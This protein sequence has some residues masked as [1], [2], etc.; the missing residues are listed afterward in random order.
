MNK[1]I[2]VDLDGTVIDSRKRSFELFRYLVGNRMTFDEYCSVKSSG[3]GNHEILKD[4][5]G[6]PLNLI[7]EFD[8]QWASLIETSEWLQ[9]DE[10]FPFTIHALR[11][12]INCHY[13][14]WLVT[15]RRNHS[16]LHHQ[17]NHL[18]LIHYFKKILMSKGVISKAITIS[19]EKKN[20]Q[21]EYIVGD[22]EEEIAVAKELGIHSI[23]VL[24]GARN[25]DFLLQ[26]GA[27]Q[28]ENSIEDFASSL[29]YEF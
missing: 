25:K 19:G 5:I 13:D 28:I 23:S 3:I 12:M 24:S 7:Q 26:A 20:E 11:Q 10:L 8:K 15:A 29:H 16:T 4:R 17:L 18:N 9:F 14:L 1:V 2:V 21:I 6:W 22:T 27:Q